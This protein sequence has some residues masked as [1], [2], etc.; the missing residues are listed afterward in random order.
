[1]VQ[2]FQSMTDQREVGE[3]IV[4]NKHDELELGAEELS[5]HDHFPQVGET[6]SVDD[7]IELDTVV[8]VDDST[9]LG[10]VDVTAFGDVGRGRSSSLAWMPHIIHLHNIQWI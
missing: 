9:G 7:G 2:K 8:S 4:T 10:S 5:T 3:V 6:D 1:M